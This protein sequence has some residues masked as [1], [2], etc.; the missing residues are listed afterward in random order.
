MDAAGLTEQPESI[1]AP[2]APPIG[3]RWLH[4]PKL[5]VP[6]P[7]HQGVRTIRLLRKG[8]A[9]WAERLTALP[10]T[11]KGLPERSAVWVGETI[12]ADAAGLPDLVT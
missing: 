4:Q 8:P 6:P 3:P 12:I 7:G 5:G 9:R 10:E 11:L 1:S 2:W